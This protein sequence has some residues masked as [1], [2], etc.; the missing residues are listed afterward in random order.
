M[1]AQAFGQSNLNKVRSVNRC[2][3]VVAKA[4]DEMRFMPV[5][6]QPK[7]RSGEFAV[8]LTGADK[9]VQK[10]LDGTLPA[11]Y[12]F[13]PLYLMGPSTMNKV[14]QQIFMRPEWLRH[15]EVFHCRWAML[16]VVGCLAPEGLGMMGLVP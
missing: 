9:N 4:E 12:G 1:V 10:Y 15:S 14:P 7:D 2:Q 6:P 5:K 16:G 8:K 11:D 3:R 13:D